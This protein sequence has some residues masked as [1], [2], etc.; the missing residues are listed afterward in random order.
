MLMTAEER[1]VRR[2]LPRVLPVF[3]LNFL[4]D[5]MKLVLFNPHFADLQTEVQQSEPKGTSVSD[6]ALVTTY[7]QFQ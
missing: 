1:W 7:S 3:T 6:A 4:E 2:T 5:P